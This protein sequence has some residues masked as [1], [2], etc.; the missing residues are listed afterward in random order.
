MLW[1]TGKLCKRSKA[2]GENRAGEPTAMS[3]ASCASSVL[4]N[5]RSDG[6][7]EQ[8]VHHGTI[9]GARLSLLE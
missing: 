9:T 8:V 6:G 5:N 3:K 2:V 7:G 1:E 4:C